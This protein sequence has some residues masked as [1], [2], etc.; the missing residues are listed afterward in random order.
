[1]KSEVVGAQT[2]TMN[3]I[4]DISAVDVSSVVGLTAMVLL[5]LNVLMGLLVSTNYNPTKQ[6]PRRRLPWPLFKIHNWTGYIALSVA[7][8]HPI[9]LL[10]S[11]TARFTLA[12]ILLPLTSPGQRLYNNL[13]ALTLYSFTIVAVTSYFRP[14]LGYRPWKKLHYIAYFAAASMFVH[15]TLIDPELKN[16]PTDFLDG[17]KVLVECC[18][19]AVAAGVVWRIRR[20]T[21]KQRYRVKSNAA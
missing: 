7:L 4:F 5:T 12:D 9:I 10:F 11:S 3:T 13:G 18:C 21:E 17:E 16:R 14:R 6:W 19:G 20:G 15:G 1:M 2:T 8:L